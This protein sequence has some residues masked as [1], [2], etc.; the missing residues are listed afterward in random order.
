[1]FQ[2][3]NAA[4]VAANRELVT[5]LEKD[6]LPRSKGSYAIGEAS[7]LAKLKYDEMVEM[8]LDA[9]L[10]R[11]Q[12]QLDKDHAAFVDT[13]RRLDPG[14]GP[15]EVMKSLSADHPTAEDL[16]PAIERSVEDARR[17]LVDKDIV[18]IPS[19]VR[20]FVRETPPF[21]RGGSFASMDTPGPFESKAKEAF[22]Y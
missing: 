11:G 20:P 7:F 14:N 9:L 6:L 3:A 1:E 4:A 8:P 18:T 16:I 12:A 17:F 21:A 2:K 22:Y 13:A 19:E 10:A 5:W 15:P